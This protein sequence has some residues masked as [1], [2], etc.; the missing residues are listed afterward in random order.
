M[1]IT[2]V[3]IPNRF[4]VSSQQFELLA[5]FNRDRRL[6]RKSDGEL[7]IMP[8]TG[9]NTGRRNFEIAVQLGIWNK[10]AKQGVAF[11]SSTGFLLP[12]GAYRSPDASW[13]ENFRWNGLTK[14]EQDGFAP[15]CPNFI[16][17]LRSLSD[18]LTPLQEK[19]KE[20]IDN[21]AKLG[22]LIDPKNRQVEIYR[23]N[24]TVEIKDNPNNLSGEDVLKGFTLD[25]AA[26]WQ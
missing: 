17:E 11:D 20:Y 25:L 12:N 5:K 10:E 15:I 1:N 8:P 7:I 18:N 14:E 22:W 6:E 21:G 2:S 4:K 19:M 23:S 13:I 26:I 24:K 9:S 16:I 3:N